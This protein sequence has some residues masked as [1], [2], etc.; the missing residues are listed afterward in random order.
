MS[1]LHIL[2]TILLHGQ[3]ACVYPAA[4]EPKRDRS[5][6]YDFFRT[7]VVRSTDRLTLV[8]VTTSDKVALRCAIYLHGSDSDSESHSDSILPPLATLILFHGNACHW[9]DITD[10]AEQFYARR[11]NVLLVS[12]RGYGTSGGFPSEKGLREDAQAV[13]EYVLADQQL[14][15]V[16]IIV[17]GHSLGGAVA[18]DLVSRN[19][20]KVSALIVENT[21]LSIRSIVRGWSVLR[22]F[23]FI[24][25]QKWDSESKI[26]SIP[27]TLPLLMLSGEADPVVPE[28]HMRKLWELRSPGDLDI[29]RSFPRG[30]HEPSLTKPEYWDTIDTFFS[31]VLQR[32]E[33]ATSSS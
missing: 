20:T 23:A 27:G 5:R 29:F 2:K 11:C 12:Y 32:Q 16:P 21:F 14:S 9:W 25:H 18:I 1:F 8:E 15:Q 24:V 6:R 28:A 10:L 4:F 26:S 3:H 30:G 22:L 7:W 13:L 19:P 33:S 17:Y 31:A